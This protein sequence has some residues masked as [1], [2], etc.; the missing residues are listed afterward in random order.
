MTIHQKLF[1]SL[2]CASAVFALVAA[3]FWYASSLPKPAPITEVLASITDASELH[4]M[5]AVS[6]LY[7]LHGVMA[8]ASIRNKW[9]SFFSFLAALCGAA[10]IGLS[11]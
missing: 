7:L 8:K 11:V 2:S 9:A 3:G 4:I 5:A 6:D 1:L 10:A